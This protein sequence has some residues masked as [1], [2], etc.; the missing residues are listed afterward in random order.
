KQ[1]RHEIPEATIHAI[2]GRIGKPTTAFRDWFRTSPSLRLCSL[3]GNCTNILLW[4]HYADSHRGL[5]IEFDTS[6]EHFGVAYKVKYERDYPVL[7][8]HSGLELAALLYKSDVWQYE[9]EYRMI[10]HAQRG[11]TPN[12]SLSD[13]MLS[14]L[15]AHHLY[16]FPPQALTA[17]I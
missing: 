12:T 4:S 7:D 5:C 8:L 10:S 6:V 2:R 1:P 17:V 13:T 11:D 3:A 16:H 15:D 9:E 14:C